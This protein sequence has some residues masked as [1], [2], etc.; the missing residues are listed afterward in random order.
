MSNMLTFVSPKLEIIMVQTHNCYWVIIVHNLVV[1]KGLN[2]CI[3]TWKLGSATS[4][5]DS[6]KMV[7]SLELG[8][9]NSPGYAGCVTLNKAL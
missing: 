5:N 8:Q 9:W 7:L 2:L 6:I 3:M 1:A 4:L